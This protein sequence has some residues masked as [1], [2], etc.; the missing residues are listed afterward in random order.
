M[1]AALLA[2][3]A[4]MGGL[5]LRTTRPPQQQCYPSGGRP[6]LVRYAAAGRTVTILGTGAP[7]TNQDLASLGNG[8][9]AINLLSSRAHVVWLVPG[10]APAAGSGQTPFT[11]LVPWPAYLITIQLAVAAVL[12]ALWRSRRLGPLV[13]ERLP[14]VV[15]AAETVEGHGRLYRARRSRDRAAAALRGAAESRLAHRLGLADGTDGSGLGGHS[16][17][18]GHPRPRWPSTPRAAA[19]CA[20]LAA[21]TGRGQDAVTAIMFGPVPQDDAALVRLADALDT[22]EKEVRTP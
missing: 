15:R 5:L 10:P 8:A 13:T 1:P 4:D 7:L 22:L 12:T 18:W 20:L 17:P 3:N 9:L 11:D 21:R 6:T 14:A 2:G 16:A 19:L